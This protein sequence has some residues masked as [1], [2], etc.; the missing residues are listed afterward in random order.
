MKEKKAFSFDAFLL[1]W[2]LRIFSWQECLAQLPATLPTTKSQAARL[3]R[4]YQITGNFCRKGIVQ[5]RDGVS[6]CNT[7]CVVF[8]VFALSWCVGQNLRVG[9]I[10]VTHFFIKLNDQASYLRFCCLCVSSNNFLRF[11]VSETLHF[12]WKFEPA[13]LQY[14]AYFHCFFCFVPLAALISDRKIRIFN[15]FTLINYL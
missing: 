10:W 5:S 4:T 7:G 2:C 11:S 12:S 9:G 8:K 6:A 13:V 14:L 15:A 1:P 3:P